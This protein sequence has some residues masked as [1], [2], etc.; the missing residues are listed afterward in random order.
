[1][2]WVVIWSASPRRFLWVPTTHISMEDWSKLSLNYHQILILKKP[3]VTLW[4]AY[5]HHFNLNNSRMHHLPPHSIA[6]TLTVKCCVF[7]RL[8][9]ES[10]LLLSFFRRRSRFLS[11]FLL[12][13]LSLLWRLLFSFPFLTFL[14]SL[15][16]LLFLLRLVAISSVLFGALSKCL[17]LHD[18]TILIL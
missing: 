17:H 18:L 14:L 8:K 11:L 7:L 16:R 6:V 9:E 4:L 10:K 5:I 12:C 15:S 1:M 13:F 2:L 3:S